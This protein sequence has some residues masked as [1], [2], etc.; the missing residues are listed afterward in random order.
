M[1]DL[2]KYVVEWTRRIHPED[3]GEKTSQLE[4][5]LRTLIQLAYQTGRVDATREIINSAK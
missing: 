2:E 5:A 3:L 4:N 1:K